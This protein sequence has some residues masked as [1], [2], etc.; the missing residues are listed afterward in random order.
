[1]VSHDY[2]WPQVPAH[3]GS[4]GNPLCRNL[5]ESGDRGRGECSRYEGGKREGE[6]ASHG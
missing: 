2:A 1:M 3:A 6:Q 5:V 4:G